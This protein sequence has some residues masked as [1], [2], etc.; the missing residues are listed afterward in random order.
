[1]FLDVATLNHE[2]R[3]GRSNL[4][5]LQL[6]MKLVDPPTDII[7]PVLVKLI[8]VNK[9]ICAIVCQVISALHMLMY[10]ALT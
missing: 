6:T 4:L 9:H 10:F 2:S 1:M 5:I 8:G 3:S 7:T